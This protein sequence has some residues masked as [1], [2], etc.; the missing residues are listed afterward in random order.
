MAPSF[1]AR[2]CWKGTSSC[3]QEKKVL[4]RRDP[5]YQGWVL[6]V[7][8][9]C[10][11]HSSPYRSHVC[12]K[13]L[14]PFIEMVLPGCSP[15]EKELP[16]AREPYHK[17]MFWLLPVSGP[18]INQDSHSFPK[19][20]PLHRSYWA[21]F[22]F[23]NSTPWKLMALG[24]LNGCGRSTFFSNRQEHL[25]S[26]STKI[27]SIFYGDGVHWNIDKLIQ[28]LCSSSCW[29][30]FQLKDSDSG[31]KHRK[32]AFCFLHHYPPSVLRDLEQV[33]QAQTVKNVRCLCLWDSERATHLTPW[34]M[35]IR[36]LCLSFPMCFP[37]F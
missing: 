11:I 4:F 28:V 17:F 12:I 5:H 24:L 37:A 32:F 20:F 19:S 36:G 1:A 23:Q 35:W 3:L 2:L 26:N 31:M 10:W 15:F 33:N 14:L 9:F 29:A 13:A 30:T 8:F 22:K 27:I 18:F 16:R 34:R 6:I 7:S 25:D 21:N